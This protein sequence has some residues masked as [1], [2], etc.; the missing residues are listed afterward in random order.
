MRAEIGPSQRARPAAAATLVLTLFG[1]A[2]VVLFSGEA[3]PPSA[4]LRPLETTGPSEPSG[5]SGPP[6]RPV[7]SSSPETA[8]EP[9]RFPAVPT[10]D[11]RAAL[12]P[13]IQSR[14]NAAAADM[15]GS[16]AGAAGSDAVSSAAL[17]FGDLILYAAYSK[18]GQGL[19]AQLQ[20][21]APA[22][23]SGVPAIPP[24]DL[25]GLSA[26]FAAAAA[27]PPLGVPAP[28]RLPTPEQAAAALAAIP[29]PIGLPAVGLPSITRLFG[30]PF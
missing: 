26:A 24:P 9:L 18:D 5:Q 25:S 6:V 1:G 15:A 7:A 20:S 30:L 17:A 19:I 23:R 10:I 8:L 3:P 14:F 21:A 27:Q 11:W 28:P 2:L 22:L 16:I 4:A 13:Y 29:P 12:Q